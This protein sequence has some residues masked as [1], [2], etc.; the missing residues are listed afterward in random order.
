MALAALFLALPCAAG[1]AR[2]EQSPVPDTA[3]SGVSA[4]EL[5]TAIDRTLVKPEYAWRAPREREAEDETKPGLLAGFLAR[6]GK[7]LRAFAEWLR[8]KVERLA[9]WLRDLLGRGDRDT[10]LSPGFVPARA[11][12]VLAALLALV[13]LGLAAHRLWKTRRKQGAIAARAVASVPDITDENVLADQLPADRW[14]EMALDFLGREECRLALRAMF[15]AALAHLGQ[16]RLIR[17]EKHKSNRDY[18]R[19][20]DRRAHDRPPLLAAFQT[21]V[22][23]LESVWYGEHEADGQTVSAFR[24]RQGVIMETAG[25]P[26]RSATPPEAEQPATRE[27]T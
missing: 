8:V 6:I 24:I 23:I 2:G 14:M 9:E 13:L 11:M 5:D 12:W 17:I 3:R 21:H 19:E 15:L 7:K 22:V 20:L 27:E 4:Q 25:N 16:C 1:N 18:G 26:P 10:G